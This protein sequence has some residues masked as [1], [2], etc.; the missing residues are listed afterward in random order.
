MSTKADCLAEMRASWGEM[1]TVVDAIPPERMDEP[2]VVPGWSVRDMLAHL[3]GY[4]RYV[5]ATPQPG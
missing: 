5:D 1:T 4:E 2:G 3:A